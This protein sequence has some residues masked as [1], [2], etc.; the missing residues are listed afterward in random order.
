[1]HLNNLISINGIYSIFQSIING[2]RL[3]GNNYIC[4]EIKI[5]SYV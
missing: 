1:M 4:I 2:N 3:N 5:G